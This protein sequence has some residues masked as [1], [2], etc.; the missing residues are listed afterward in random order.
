MCKF[1]C[2]VSVSLVQGMCN[3]QLYQGPAQTPQLCQGPAQTPQLCQ[4]PFQTSQLCM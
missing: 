3:T 1:V 4:G 2:D